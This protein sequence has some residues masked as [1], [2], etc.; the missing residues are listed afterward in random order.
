MSNQDLI[1]RGD[2]DESYIL[3]ALEDV[4][5]MDVT[6]PMYA[7]AVAR[8]LAAIPAVDVAGGRSDALREAAS[9]AAGEAA[10]H[11]CSELAPFLRRR[12]LAL[13]D[14]PDPAPDKVA[15]AAELIESLLEGYGTERLD[16]ATLTEVTAEAEAFLTALKGGDA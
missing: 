3:A 10:A 7:A 4:H 12:I 6:L 9:E 13:I 1:R 15:R 8:A 14:A 5:D 11:G 2:A 16:F